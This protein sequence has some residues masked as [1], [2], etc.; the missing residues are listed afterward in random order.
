[1]FM[2]I[3]R[4]YEA[5]LIAIKDTVQLVTE[6]VEFFPT[7]AKT[8]TDTWT[9][10][11]IRWDY[12]A[13]MVRQ[14]AASAAIVAQVGTPAGMAITVPDLRAGAAAG[15]TYTLPAHGAA[16][17]AAAAEP[18][19][20]ILEGKNLVGP[21]G[22]LLSFRREIEIGRRTDIMLGVVSMTR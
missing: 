5:D 19:R 21:D 16:T 17:A 6:I 7:V 11:G 10:G 9:A 14:M 3:K 18:T 15:A 4:D 8:I 1:M 13:E 20:I 2:D 22:R 12:L